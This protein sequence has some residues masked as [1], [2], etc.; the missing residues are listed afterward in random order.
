[1]RPGEPGPGQR[2]PGAA[3]RAEARGGVGGGDGPEAAAARDGRPPKPGAQLRAGRV[4]SPARRRARARPAGGGRGA[5]PALGTGR[6]S[7]LPGPTKSGVER[8][9]AVV[10]EG[11]ASARQRRGD[12]GAREGGGSAAACGRPA[13]PCAK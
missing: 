1:M 11:R 13:R 6:R 3:E 12:G 8:S 7:P 4:R 2:A 9:A 5:V 10:P